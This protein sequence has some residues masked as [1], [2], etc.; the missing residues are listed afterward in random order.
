M[1]GNDFMAWMLRSPLHGMLSGST[2]LITVTGRK[3]GKK[4]TTPINYFE[5]DGYLWVVSNRDRTWWKNVQGGADVELLLKRSLVHGHAETE[6][7]SKSVEEHLCT[8]IQRMPQA[9]K[10]LGVRMVDHQPNAEDIAR[11]AKDRLFVRIRT[12]N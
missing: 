1:N 2:A 3:T 11:A 10:P 7:D 8:Y 4:Y 5:E 6:M 9:A 12:S